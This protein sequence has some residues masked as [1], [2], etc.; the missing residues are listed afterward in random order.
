MARRFCTFETGARES[1]PHSTHGVAMKKVPAV[2]PA[3]SEKREKEETIPNSQVEVAEIPADELP[4]FA[5]L[6]QTEY[7]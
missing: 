7:E 5:L 3:K 4:D 2:L 1:R 6:M